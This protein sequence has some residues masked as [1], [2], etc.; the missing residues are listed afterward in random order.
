MK[1]RQLSERTGLAI[2]KR[3]EALGFSQEGF[4]DKIDMHRTYYSALERGENNLTLRTLKRVC[5]GLGV[6]IWEI[7]KDADI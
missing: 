3:R 1:D 5:A 6:K 2:R 4:A 7:L